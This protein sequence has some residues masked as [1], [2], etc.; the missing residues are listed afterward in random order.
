MSYGHE[1][2]WLVNEI[3]KEHR[4]IRHHWWVKG[5]WSKTCRHLPLTP[6]VKSWSIKLNSSFAVYFHRAMI[7]PCRLV[8]MWDLNKMKIGNR[9]ALPLLLAGFLSH[10]WTW[11]YISSICVCKSHQTMSSSG[12]DLGQQ[13]T[14]IQNCPWMA[15]DP[16][17]HF[18]SQRDFPC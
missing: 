6:R 8:S 16:N 17:S 14:I 3:C 11:P 15:D 5:I 10:A 13:V 18:P 9:S 7:S 12:N 1:W 4:P 2:S